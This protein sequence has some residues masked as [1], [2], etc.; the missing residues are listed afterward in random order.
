MDLPGKRL[1]D[2]SA[3]ELRQRF[4]KSNRLH[5]AV[6]FD[7]LFHSG[8]VL[9]DATLVVHAR[10]AKPP[11]HAAQP[12]APPQV[13]SGGRIGISISKRVG[14]APLRN[15]WKRLIREA[16]RKLYAD[17]QALQRLDLVVRPRRGASPEYQAIHRS[18]NQ[19]STRL[20]RQLLRD[21]DRKQAG[22]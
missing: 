21:K 17:S 12:A 20:E 7:E 3:D 16:Y 9:A 6:E 13:T 4:P 1:A 18:L 19:L 8:R 22:D 14:H 11:S 5:S 10:Q 15:R 2:R